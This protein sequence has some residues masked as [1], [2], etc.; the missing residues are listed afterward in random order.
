MGA[1]LVFGLSRSGLA[2]IELLQREGLEV[3]CWDDDRIRFESSKLPSG[4][5]ALDGGL[6]KA[7]ER[8]VALAVLSPGI[9]PDSSGMKSLE[10]QGIPCISELELAW[11][12]SQSPCVIVT[13]T[14]GKSSAVSLIHSLFEAAGLKTRLCGNIGIPF[15]RVVAETKSKV[16]DSLDWYV[17]EASSYQLAL[18]PSLHPK[19]MVYTNFAEDHLD[20][21][22]SVDAYLRAK[23]DISYVLGPEDYLVYPRESSLLSKALESSAAQRLTFGLSSSGAHVELNDSLARL[24]SKSFDLE[25]DSPS[26]G[27]SY[28]WRPL[29]SSLQICVSLAEIMGFDQETLIGGLRSFKPLEHRLEYAGSIGRIEFINDSKAT[30]VDATAYALRMC[31]APMVLL[32]GGKHKGVSYRPFS[33]QR[34]KRS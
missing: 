21:H 34:S 6:A 3:F 4:V 28:Q 27:L 23:T 26:I 13:G 16:E 9:A 33:H 8:G 2:S 30:N 20:W 1:V 15:S 24:K 19:V 32:L 7:K 22:G 25:L 18:S 14:N 5:R 17:V 31:K 29:S 11:R 12:Y 10:S